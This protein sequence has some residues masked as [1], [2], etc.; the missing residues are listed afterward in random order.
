MLT[1]DTVERPKSQALYAGWRTAGHLGGTGTVYG[2]R[3]RRGRDGRPIIGGVFA[4]LLRRYAPGQ[5]A[6]ARFGVRWRF[7][8]GYIR[9]LLALGAV[10]WAY[11][12][13]F[14]ADDIAQVV[15]TQ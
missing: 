10:I 12:L 15:L 11:I 6:I 13:L 9:G 3:A 5:R 2:R 4:Q 8:P 1:A 7:L 14:L